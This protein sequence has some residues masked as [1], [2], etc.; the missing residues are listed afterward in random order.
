MR[1]RRPSRWIFR[2][3]LVSLC[4][5]RSCTRSPTSLWTSRI[6][7]LTLGRSMASTA[8][9]TRGG[10]RLVA[11]APILANPLNVVAFALIAVFAFCALFAPLIAPDDPLPQDLGSR[12]M[13]PSPAHWLGDR[14]PGRDLPDPIPHR[15]R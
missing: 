2:R 7:G 6:S 11:R 1:P 12:L 8:A 3:S 9:L 13:P 10:L 14:P 5:P 4:W 15:A